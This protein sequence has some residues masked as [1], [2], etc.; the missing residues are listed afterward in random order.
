MRQKLSIIFTYCWADGALK[1]NIQSENQQTKALCGLYCKGKEVVI[2]ENLLFPR[3]CRVDPWIY[4]LFTEGFSGTPSL[5]LCTWSECQTCLTLA[6]HC[7]VLPAF[8]HPCGP[9]YSVIVRTAQKRSFWDKWDWIQFSH[10]SVKL[11][12]KYY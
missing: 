9:L 7:A 4:I 1:F 8:L 6:W 10:A 2:S 12:S 11:V 5:K 3:Q